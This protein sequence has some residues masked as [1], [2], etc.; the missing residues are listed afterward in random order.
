MPRNPKFKVG[1]K[2][3]VLRASTEEEYD[4]WRDSWQP[5][6]NRVVGK[7]MTIIRVYP[8]NCSPYPKYCLEG[9]GMNFPE[10]VLEK[11]IRIGQQLMF[12]FM[13]ED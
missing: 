4:L 12:D 5:S 3:R 8:N 13:R 11:E 10:F 7:V 6:M 1:D 9:T 2:V